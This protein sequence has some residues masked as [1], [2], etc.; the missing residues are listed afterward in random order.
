MSTNVEV[1]KNDLWAAG[2]WES[3]LFK[4]H[5]ALQLFEFG[6]TPQLAIA[7]QRQINGEEDEDPITDPPN[8]SVTMENGQ[9]V[10][11]IELAKSAVVIEGEELSPAIRSNYK[12][13][14]WPG[15]WNSICVTLSEVEEVGSAPLVIRQHE[16]FRFSGPPIKQ[17]GSTPNQEDWPTLPSFYEAT[18]AFPPDSDGTDITTR[19]LLVSFPNQIIAQTLEQTR[20]IGGYLN[21]RNLIPGPFPSNG[22]FKRVII[23]AKTAEIL[24]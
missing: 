8:F 6:E 20:S 21:D 4:T 11:V 12:I 3:R 15:A 23:K 14:W 17:I 22:A 19:F 18:S 9:V 7:L 16:T 5:G 2:L 10:T 24:A 1:L 13:K